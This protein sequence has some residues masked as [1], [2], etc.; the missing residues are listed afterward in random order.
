MGRW[1]FAYVL[2]VV[3][4]GFLISSVTSERDSFVFAYNFF[5]ATKSIVIVNIVSYSNRIVQK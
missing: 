1:L 5:F 2:R 3:C 4:V